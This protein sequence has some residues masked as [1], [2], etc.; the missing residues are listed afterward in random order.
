MS[1]QQSRRKPRA[2]DPIIMT[3]PAPMP[4][5][6]H[7]SSA[8]S[9]A[10]QN[11]LASLRAK[12]DAVDS[13]LLVL[14]NQRAIIVQQ[15]GELKK[16]EGLPVFSPGREEQLLHRL[17]E[18]S[19]GPLPAASIRAIYREILSASRAVEKEVVIACLGPS[20]GPTH[21][22]AAR[23][24][25]SSVRYVFLREITDVFEQVT[26]NEADC[27]I[28][29][30]ETAERG[31]AEHS[32][33]GLVET[34]LSVCAE[35]TLE[36]QQNEGDA[37]RFL[38]VSRTPNPPSGFDRTLIALRVEDKP[39]ALI[40]ALEPFKEHSINLSHLAS[41][42][43]AKG[44]KDL[45]FFVEAEGHSKELQTSDIFRELSKRCRAVK[46]LGSYPKEPSY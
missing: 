7:V 12:I 41:R 13:Q 20:G 27:G 44:S 22:A 40:S 6:H 21:Q 24:F 38:V 1:G 16:R 8:Q 10:A 32:L 28:V 2:K 18:Q 37:E 19:K 30:I 43:A 39:G 42:P 15:V 9:P 26:K 23:R 36:G 3:D 29:P 4:S 46:I 11:T 25:G 33:N 45:F 35:I 17:E 34:E 14:L 31:F 5:I